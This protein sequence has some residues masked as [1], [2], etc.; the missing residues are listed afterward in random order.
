MP[1]PGRVDLGVGD[2]DH[3]AVGT[4][5]S[6]GEPRDVCGQERRGRVGNRR[7]ARLSCLA[8]FFAAMVLAAPV[9]WNA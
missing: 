6:G 3:I 8:L 7:E 5:G 1:A 9:A 4:G 2:D